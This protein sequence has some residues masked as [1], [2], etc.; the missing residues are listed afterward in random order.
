MNLRWGIIG[1][2]KIA[3][4]FADALTRVPGNS[5]EAVASRDVEKA[6]AFAKVFGVP[7]A[8]GSYEALAKDED[9]DAV[10]VATP[11]SYHHD[12][13]ILCLSNR[14]AVLCEKPISVNLSSAMEMVHAARQQKVFLM[15]AFW[16]R[17][18]PVIKSLDELLNDKVI[19]DI[20]YIRADFGI[21]FEFNPTSRIFDL[22]LGG[23]RLLNVGVYRLVLV[24]HG[25][26]RR[27]HVI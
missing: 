17:F 23:G 9:V 26:G 20:K 2:G 13:S 5:L 27:N 24:M 1:P 19:G 8:L 12:H 11:H 10:Y 18:M 15:E 3:K 21:N 22:K 14:K 16:T 25:L 7:K 4:K 6:R